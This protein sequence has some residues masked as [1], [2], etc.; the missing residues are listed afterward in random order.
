MGIDTLK[1]S[2]YIWNVNNSTNQETNM[3]T[4]QRI[5]EILQEYGLTVNQLSDVAA[6]FD[7]VQTEL[8]EQDVR[9]FAE[10]INHNKCKGV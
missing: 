10:L 2:G 8:T 5:R 7:T 1:K 9:D 3:I 6:Y 4:R